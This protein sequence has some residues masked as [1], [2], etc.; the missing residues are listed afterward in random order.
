[1]A[2]AKHQQQGGH[3]GDAECGNRK[4]WDNQIIQ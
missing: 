2:N 1:M 3:A 4:K